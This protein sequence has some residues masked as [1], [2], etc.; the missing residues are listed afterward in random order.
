MKLHR[1]WAMVVS[2][3][4]LLTLT[5]IAVADN[6]YEEAIHGD[7]SGDRT[8][9]T[10]YDLTLGRNVISAT[11][12][13]GDREY[14]AIHLP[15]GSQLE[16][17]IL[18]SYDSSDEVA[19]IGMQQGIT[20]TEV[21]T[22]ANP[23]NLLGWAHFGPKN[24]PIGSDILDDMAAMTNTIG[25]TTPLASGDYVLWLQQTG[26]TTT[27]FALDLMVAPT[28]NRMAY[29]EATMGDLSTDGTK[30]TTITLSL[31]GNII[32]G[33]T[34][35]R[36][37]EYFS[38][39]VPLG[40]EVQA[41][42]LTDYESEDKKSFIGVQKGLQFTEPPSGTVVSNLLGWTHFGPATEPVG[43]DMLDNIGQGLG[44]QGFSGTLSAGDYTFWLQQ[45]GVT[46]TTYAVNFV[47]STV[48]SQTVYDEALD[49]DL[50]NDHAQPTTVTL[51][52]GGNVISQTTQ[53]GDREYYTIDVPVG[54]QLE[55]IFLNSYNSNDETSFIGVQK[56]IT[57]TKSAAE[58]TQADLLGWT[59]FGPSVEAVGNNILDNMGNGAG[60]IGFSGALPSG[61]YSFWTQQA[62]ATPT[63]IELNFVI[64][65]VLPQPPI[66]TEEIYLPLI[67]R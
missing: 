34:V 65:K 59:H 2:A 23:G 22:N 21:P 66:E 57:F 12:V 16:Q 61:S 62:S 29:D 15:S 40:Q 3:T 6:S 45:T 47:L 38:L 32:S 43:A 31:G 41:I 26:V 25:F 18:S 11:S 53:Q 8:A 5:L 49:G 1:F 39:N 52:S 54:H 46:T 51:S 37:R 10:Q 30:P 67:I 48:L 58:T 20:F 55:A 63:Q 44:A 27:T 4:L 24:T 17:I 28:V 56:G 14:V 7:L 42:L 19:F 33:T 36:D 50:S 64:S 9:P 60:A 13:R 35:R